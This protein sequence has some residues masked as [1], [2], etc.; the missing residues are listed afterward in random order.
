MSRTKKSC[1]NETRIMKNGMKATCIAYRLAKDI[2]VQFEDGTIIEHVQKVHFYKGSITNPNSSYNPYIKLNSLYETNPELMEEWD[3]D[4]N[5]ISPKEI[6]R[7][8]N[9]SVWWKCKHG[10]SWK[11]KVAA[12]T[13]K[14]PTGCPYCSGQLPITGVNDFATLNP[15]LML[16]WDFNK[17]ADVDPTKITV[18][19]GMYVDWKCHFC[20]HEWRT[21]ANNRSSAKRGCPNCSMKST[22]FGEQAVYYYVKKIFA[23]AIN[24][25]RDGRFELDIYIPSIKTGIEFDGVYFHNGKESELR[26]KRK[27]QKCQELGIKLIRIKD[28][29]GMEGIVQSDNAIGIENLK[30]NDNLNKIIRMLLKNLDPASNVWARKNPRQI[31]STIDHLVD[32]DKDYFDIVSDKY[33]REEE[34]SFVNSNPELL[35]DWDYELNK[36]INPKSLTKGCGFKLNWRCHICGYKWKAR[37]PDR[38]KGAGCPCCGR[39]VLVPG[40][41]DFATLHP[42]E[43][44]EWDYESNNVNPKRILSYNE[45]VAW[46]C[47]KCGYKWKATIY[48]K[49]IRKDKTGCPQCANNTI[50]AKRH[51]RAMKN[52]GLFDKYPELLKQWNYD[53]NKDV[54]INDISSGSGVRYWWICDECGYEWESSPNNRTHGNHVRGCPKCRY[55]KNAEK[56]RNAK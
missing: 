48:D 25:Y 17:N 18:H 42:E 13:R 19:S 31:W 50:A 35:K 51:Q 6:T 4:K 29:V 9:K 22:S 11:A 44:I 27:Y 33:L 16:D 38:L 8:Y 14:N 41:N 24:R 45:K 36:N 30:D 47:S 7:S 15:E 21:R 3:Y 37:I 49:V 5:S 34:N 46:K 20:G 52:G 56:N 10:H 23:D 54:N 2:D 28:S 43:L 12:R 32:V 53:K 39:K 40:V 1:L 55:K 26:E